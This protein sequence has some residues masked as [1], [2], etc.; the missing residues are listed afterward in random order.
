MWWVG[1]W[2]WVRVWMM[3]QTMTGWLMKSSDPSLLVEKLK[4]AGF[5]LSASGGR[6]QVGPA[7]LLTDELRQSIRE[8]R[9]GIIRILAAEPA[10]APESYPSP[11]PAA[12]VQP[13]PRKQPQRVSCGVCLHFLPGQP[14][15]EQS[16]GRCGLTRAG[17]PSPKHG[18]YLAC[19]PR[20]PRTCSQFQHKEPTS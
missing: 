17:P 6:L 10:P 1:A 16:L 20:A 9:A 14:L 3:T 7:V 8:H 4:A 18:D 12:S 2:S 5:T 13:A 15:P 19:F 11:T